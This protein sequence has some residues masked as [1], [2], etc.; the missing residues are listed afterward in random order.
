MPHSP[1][2]TFLCHTTIPLPYCVPFPTTHYSRLPFVT[3]IPSTTC[4]APWVRATCV[5]AAFY[6][7]APGRARVV[8]CYYRSFCY[9][10]LVVTTVDV[11][12]TPTFYRDLL[13]R[14]SLPLPHLAAFTANAA[15]ATTVACTHLSFSA[16]HLFTLYLLV[17]PPAAPL[18]RYHCVR[19][20]QR[21]YGVTPA[22]S[23]QLVS[24]D[25]FVHD[26]TTVTACTCLPCAITLTPAFLRNF[27]TVSL[28]RVTF[29][30]GFK[31]LV[32]DYVSC[33]PHS[34]PVPLTTFPSPHMPCALCLSPLTPIPLTHTH[35]HATI[36]LLF[37]ATAV[38]HSHCSSVCV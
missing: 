1:T 12:P 24:C 2:T 3:A 13:Y 35:T 16:T 22:V 20:C 19:T 36:V 37:H 4:A 38:P 5:C 6:H 10:T 34:T 14:S 29:L 31:F 23:L 18:L 17:R 28:Y 9:R 8:L 7:R 26:R 15:G 21:V 30:Y 33:C 32:P 11:R 25:H 27:T